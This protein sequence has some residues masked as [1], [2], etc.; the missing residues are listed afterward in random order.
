MR[1]ARRLSL[2]RQRMSELYQHER[3]IARRL[4]DAALPRSLPQLPGLT[5]DAYYH[6]G[7]DQAQIG[8]D[9]YDAARLPDGRVILTIGA[10]LGSVFLIVAGEFLR[11]LGQINTFVVAAV[12]LAVILFFPDGLLGN[13]LRVTARERE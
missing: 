11:P 8:G 1:R 12:A 4:Q 7:S 9:W 6:A 3:R 5:F 10:V 13:L 2:R